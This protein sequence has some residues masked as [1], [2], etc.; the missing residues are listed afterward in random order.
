MK[1]GHFC[2]FPD[3]LRKF[4]IF[5]EIHPLMGRFAHFW[6]KVTKLQNALKSRVL[7][8]NASEKVQRHLLDVN[9][10]F[11]RLTSPRIVIRPLPAGFIEFWRY[12]GFERMD[13][14]YFATGTA[15]R[16]IVSVQSTGKARGRTRGALG[17]QNRAIWG[18]IIPPRGK[19]TSKISFFAHQKND[20]KSRFSRIF[21]VV[22]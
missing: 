5:R 12:F 20:K 6:K 4:H 13:F 22:R 17:K 9:F 8:Q 16:H 21:F 15:I 3:F 1:S 11:W 7:V 14:A 2:D 19:K 10:R 18:H